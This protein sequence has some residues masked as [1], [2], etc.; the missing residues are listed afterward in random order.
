ME[1]QTTE[2]PAKKTKKTPL[3]TIKIGETMV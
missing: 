2:V 1:T 3:Q